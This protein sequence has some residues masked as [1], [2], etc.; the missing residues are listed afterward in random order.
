M[1]SLLSFKNTPNVNSQKGFDIM[2]QTRT[3]E[4]CFI[5]ST[6]FPLNKFS[7]CKCSSSLDPKDQWLKL[8]GGHERPGSKD[9]LLI[10]TVALTVFHS[11]TS[12]EMS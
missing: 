10:H 7:L 4:P 6:Q 11:D 2:E 1:F 3:G 5:W 12:V 9:A 8:G